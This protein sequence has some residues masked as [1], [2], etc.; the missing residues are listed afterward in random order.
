MR[1][2]IRR[3]RLELSDGLRAHIEQRLRAALGRFARQVAQVWVYLRDVNGPRGGEDKCCRIVVHLA[4][5]GRAVAGGTGADPYA[6][7]AR[8][9]AR[10][11]R[12]V[13][14]HFQRGVARRARLWGRRGP[15][16]A[17]R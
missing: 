8:T 3:R 11:A 14:R 10:S 13:K 5:G 16:R 17:A 2:E 6:V 12:V 7:V 4:R 15:S 9:A 1:L